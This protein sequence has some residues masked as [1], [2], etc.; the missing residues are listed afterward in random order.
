MAHEGKHC[1]IDVV[2][3]PAYELS[4]LKPDEQQML[5]ETMDYEQARRNLHHLKTYFLNLL[6]L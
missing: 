4:F 3:Y 5:V 6:L 2:Q 1:F